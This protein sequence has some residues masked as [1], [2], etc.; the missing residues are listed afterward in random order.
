MQNETIWATLKTAIID[1]MIDVPNEL[2]NPQQ[3]LRDLGANSL[4]RAEIIMKTMVLLKLQIP[5]LSFAK[6][7]NINELIAIF[8]SHMPK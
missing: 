6:A 2:L 5:L 7:N 8:A 3:S 1:I 4:D